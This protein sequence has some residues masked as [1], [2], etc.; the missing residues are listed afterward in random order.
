V[1]H[2]GDRAEPL[3]CALATRGVVVRQFP[4]GALGVAPPL[5]QAVAAARALEAAL[6]AALEEVGR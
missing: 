5:D 2:A 4:N 3:A 1:I 6:A